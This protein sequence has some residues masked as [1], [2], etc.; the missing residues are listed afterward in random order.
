MP[1]VLL[2]IDEF[3][4]TCLALLSWSHELYDAGH[5]LEAALA[6]HTYSKLFVSP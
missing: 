1:R 5:L 6:H 3:G 2:D 4:V